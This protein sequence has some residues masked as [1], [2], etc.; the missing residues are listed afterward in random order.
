[1]IRNMKVIVLGLI[2]TF[3]ISYAF[4]AGVYNDPTCSDPPNCNT[5]LPVNVSITSQAKSGSL[6]I[7]SSLPM[8]T[9]YVFH[10]DGASYLQNLVTNGFTLRGGHGEGNVLKYNATSKTANWQDVSASVSNSA[11]SV[12]DFSIK[13]L[14]NTTQSK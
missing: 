4:A 13:V 2:I 7:G 6:K 5:D 14:S 10:V 1:M 12:Q 8:A 9:G 3:G 11:I